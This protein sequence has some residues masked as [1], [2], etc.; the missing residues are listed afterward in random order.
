MSGNDEVRFSTRGPL[1]LITLTR[2]KALNALTLD[3]IRA[4]GPQLAAWARDSAVKAVVIEGEG[5]RAFCAGGD[6]RAVW[7]AGRAGQH[8]AGQEG[9]ITADFFRAEYRLNRQIQSYPKPYVA[10]IDGITMGGGVGLSIHGLVRLATERTLFAMP[11][12]AIGL[13][14]DVGG[15]Y[16]LPRLPGGLG[17]YL[18]LTGAR[19]KA[20]DCLY[21]GIATHYA[22]AAEL[23]RVFDALLGCDW[24]QGASGLRAALRGVTGQP[25][26]AGTLAALRP[27][28][29]RCFKDKDS[30]EAVLAALAAEDTPWGQETLELLARRSPTSLRVALE[31]LRRGATLGFDDCMVMEYRLSQA[32]MR[33]GSDFYEGIRA[34]LVDKD[35]APKWNPA[36]LQDVTPTLVDAYFAPLGQ[37]ELTF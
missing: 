26:E 36:R 3:M 1:G 33:P 8:K 2:P 29:D 22:P 19:L 12:T 31:Q 25:D 7:E 11:E 17:L 9:L 37:H 13:F 28:I 24:S 15:S 20:A 21:S 35:H 27:A 16:F 23:P 4:I 5:E 14:P 34:L 10:L 30:V 32:A 6:V 18:A